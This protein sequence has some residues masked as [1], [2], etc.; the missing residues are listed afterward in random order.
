MGVLL[1]SSEIEEVLGLAHRVY[2]M[3]QGR[4]M[5]ELEGSALTEDAVMRAIFATP[6]VN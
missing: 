5:A 6:Q 2:A 1:I 3:R 4:I